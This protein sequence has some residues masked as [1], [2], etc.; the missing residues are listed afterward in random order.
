MRRLEVWADSYKEGEWFITA[1]ADFAGVKYDVDYI[2]NFQPRFRF[3]GLHEFEAVVYGDYRSW[4]PLPPA[5]SDI[6][7]YGK[8]DIMLYDRSADRVILGIEETA[9]V[10][11]GN[12]ALQRLE[13][14]VYSAQSSVPFIYLIAEY[15]LHK[16]GGVRR[17][18]I[19]P[20]YLA[21]KLTGHYGVPSL[22][23]LYGDADHPE[24]YE[25]GEGVRSMAELGWLFVLDW[26]GDDV[27]GAKKIAYTQAYGE[28]AEFIV[29]HAD[30]ISPRLPGRDVLGAEA[31]A[32]YVGEEAAK[33]EV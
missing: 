23:L 8:P 28:M 15:G 10:P 3:E 5:V 7:A 6:I 2:H 18:S 9:A 33:Y 16:D 26:L 1:V 24:D 20:S 27:R 30:D 19:W 13:R 11:T 4:N 31:F 22:T 32:E 12:Q 25:Y 21:L 14:V 17:T 29:D